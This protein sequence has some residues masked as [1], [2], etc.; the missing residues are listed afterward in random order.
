MATS[1]WD[2]CPPTKGEA[3]FEK[4]QT[5][6]NMRSPKNVKEVQ[7]LIW[8]LTTISR[9]LPWLTYKSHLMIRLLQKS[10]KFFWD[11]RCQ[12]KFEQLKQVLASPPIL[13]KLNTTQSLLAYI[14]IIKDA[15]NVTLVQ[16]FGNEQKLIYFISINLQDVKIRYQM[17]KKVSL[18]L[19]TIVRKLCPYFQSHL[20]MVKINYSIHKILQKLGIV[21]RMSSWSVELLEFSIRYELRELIK[22]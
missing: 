9:F 18:C 13:C 5:A 19:V 22:A 1:S 12:E 14:T 4:C 15:I 7:W 21:G 16:D 11:D 3:N 10:T 6:T 20:V 2:S 17:V 8:R